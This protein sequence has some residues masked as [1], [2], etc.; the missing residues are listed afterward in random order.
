MLDRIPIGSKIAASF[1]LLL[2]PIVVIGVSSFKALSGASQSISSYHET[3]KKTEAIG[4]LQLAIER[5]AMPVND[6]II[7]KDLEEVEAYKELR[8]DIDHKISELG[9]MMSSPEAK[10]LIAGIKEDMLIADSKAQ[11]VFDVYDKEEAAE[12]MEDY[13]E[14]A[15]KVAD[16]AEKLHELVRDYSTHLADTISATERRANIVNILSLAMALL[17]FFTVFAVLRARVINPSKEAFQKLAEASRSL[18]SSAQ[19]VALS[20]TQAGNANAEIAGIISNFSLGSER[21]TGAVNEVDELVSQISAAINQVAG[22][23]QEQARDVSEAHSMIEQ[24]SLAV[25]DMS[26]NAH[27]VARVASESLG[28]AENGKKS[29]DEAVSGVEK[30]KDTIL[31][32]ANK[33]QTLGEKSKQIGEIIEVIDDIA[34]QTNL[35]ALNAAIEAAR[36]GEH[37]KGFAVVADEVRKLAE[38][39][40]K[41]TG[42]IAELI[43]GIQDETMEAVSSMEKGTQEVESANELT[44]Q[45]GTAIDE[46]MESTEEVMIQ[47]SSVRSASMKM[48]DSAE[49]VLKAINGIASV[50]EENTA[51]TQQ[52]AASTDQVS[53][54]VGDVVRESEGNLAHMQEISSSAQEASA[55]VEQIS[56]TMQQLAMM[57][58]ELDELVKSFN[59]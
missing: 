45:V 41:A 54:T 1:A 44:Q 42:E 15:S 7:T 35:L 36:A 30:M 27:V 13:D 50:T 43:K 8:A 49:K 11:Y 18:S 23:A 9:T 56:A 55:S 20:S 26:E 37:G 32:S 10:Q 3:L 14:T 4:S 31:S 24:L 39:S 53:K 33:I 46:M 51:L 6:V 16:D 34:E 29:V 57:S 48:T 38:R 22:G 58:A 25:N 40:A 28:T 19:E 2:I 5:S 52:V 47:I 59:W 21:Q 17:I 12:A